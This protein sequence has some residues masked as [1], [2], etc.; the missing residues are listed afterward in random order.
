MQPLR[1]QELSASFFGG[2]GD[3]LNSSRERMPVL[4]TIEPFQGDCRAGLTYPPDAFHLG[5]D[6]GTWCSCSACV[7]LVFG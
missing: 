1:R 4:E 5:A 3:K 2:L 7:Q 6:S